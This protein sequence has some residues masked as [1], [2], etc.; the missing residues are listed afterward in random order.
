[1]DTIFDFTN[2]VPVELKIQIGLGPTKE[3]VTKAIL[4]D[5]QAS[6]EDVCKD[7]TALVKLPNDIQLRD[8]FSS[9]IY[10]IVDNR[11]LSDTR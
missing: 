3:T 2:M 1:M 9:I 10:S 8:D 4:I 5:K 7:L 6:I 11:K